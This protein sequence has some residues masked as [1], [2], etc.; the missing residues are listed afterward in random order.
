MKDNYYSILKERVK[1]EFGNSTDV[2]IYMFDYIHKELRI[3]FKRFFDYDE[4]VFSKN[5]GD[6]YILKSESYSDT[7][8]FTETCDILS[9]LYDEFNDKLK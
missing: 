7:K 3:G 2:V 5:D 1:S 8:F 6:L 9:K 4:I